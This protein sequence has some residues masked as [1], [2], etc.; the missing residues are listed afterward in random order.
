MKIKLLAVGKK[1][2]AWVSEGFDEYAKRFP[3]DCKLELIEINAGKRGKNAPLARIKEAEGESILQQIKPTDWVVVLDV[4]GKNW[5]TERLSEYMKEWMHKGV[6]IC[7]LVG[8]PEGLSDA[9]YERANQRWSLSNLTLPHPMV[10]VIL[11][12]ALYRGWSLM[13]NH[14]YH[15]A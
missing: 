2:P 15:R 6:D 12:E 13:A 3:R 4:Q 9:C 14:P 11:A 1:M 8:G 7:L 5:S 10:R